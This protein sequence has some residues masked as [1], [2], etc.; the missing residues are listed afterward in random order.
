MMKKLM[1]ICLALAMALACVG[2][3]AEGEGVV[4]AFAESYQTFA[5]ETH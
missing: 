2:A 1:C 4:A 3:L 5:G